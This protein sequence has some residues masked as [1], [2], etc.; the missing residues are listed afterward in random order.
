[1][2]VL[3]PFD[4]VYLALDLTLSPS[5]SHK[6]GISKLYI[7]SSSDTTSNISINAA[8]DDVVG[9]VWAFSKLNEHHSLLEISNDLDAIL[10]LLVVL[11]ATISCKKLDKGGGR[12]G[13]RH[14]DRLEL[15][16]PNQSLQ[17]VDTGDGCNTLQYAG[18]ATCPWD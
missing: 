15:P 14:R 16:A 12:A 3:C 6:L 7:S 10:R 13:F 4:A 2:R 1:M 11:L 9:G 18:T 5:E 8:L 17:L